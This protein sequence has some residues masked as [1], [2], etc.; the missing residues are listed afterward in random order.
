VRE[1]GRRGLQQQCI[2]HLDIVE[3]M[4]VEDAPMPGRFT[5]R[6]GVV[7]NERMMRDRTERVNDD[8]DR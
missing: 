7:D 5:W 3:D 8:G 4:S 1:R 2:V 6:W